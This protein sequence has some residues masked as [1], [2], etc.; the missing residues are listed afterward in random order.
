MTI[1]PADNLFDLLAV[2]HD[3]FHHYLT[4]TRRLGLQ[5]IN[6]L[7][8][9]Y[10]TFVSFGY[11]GTILASPEVGRANSEVVKSGGDGLLDVFEVQAPL[12]ASYEGSACQQVVVQHDF[13]ASYGTPFVGMNARTRTFSK[14]IM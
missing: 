5:L 9:L 13:A 4:A 12:R 2:Q 1:V 8:S 14:L 3:S 6:M 7:R 10:L 11:L